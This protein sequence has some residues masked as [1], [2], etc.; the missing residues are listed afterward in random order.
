[1]DL[2][3]CSIAYF[4]TKFFITNACL[5]DYD[6]NYEILKL[7]NFT[8]SVSSDV[9]SIAAAG[10]GISTFS[11]CRSYILMLIHV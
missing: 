1:V 10:K 3:V 7:N 2:E 6:G 4:S 9:V 8:N 5:L 11:C